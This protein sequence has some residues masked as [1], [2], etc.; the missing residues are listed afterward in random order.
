MKIFCTLVVLV[1]GSLV[2][3]AEAKKCTEKEVLIT[4]RSSRSVHYS[5]K[6]EGRVVGKAKILDC[7]PSRPSNPPPNSA[8]TPSNP[9][10]VRSCPKF[11]LDC[12][13]P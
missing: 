2:F 9:D 6:D 13:R 4:L 3:G 7:G 5:E 10:Y 12:I 1:A 11:V 8:K